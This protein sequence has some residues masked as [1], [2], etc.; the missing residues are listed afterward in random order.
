[1]KFEIHVHEGYLEGRVSQICYLG[2]FILCIQSFKNDKMLPVCHMKQKLRPKLKKLR[3]MSLKKNCKEKN[4]MS[5]N[6]S[7]ENGFISIFSDKQSCSY[8]SGYIQR[9]E[10]AFYFI[11]VCV[12]V[13]EI[14]RK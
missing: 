11:I 8:S 14:V 2:F 7:D 6:K 12:D 5:K 4:L 10:M 1:M 13:H 9:K 3:H